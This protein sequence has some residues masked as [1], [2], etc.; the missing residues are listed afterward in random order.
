MHLAHTPADQDPLSRAL[1][2]FLA[3]RN[4]GPKEVNEIILFHKIITCGMRRASLT[5]AI[6]SRGMSGVWIWTGKWQ[7]QDGGCRMQ[8]Q[9]HH[10]PNQTTWGERQPS[11]FIVFLIVIF[12]FFLLLPGAFEKND[13][14]TCSFCFKSKQL[15][16]QYFNDCVDGADLA[17]NL[18]STF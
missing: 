8:S 11:L 18:A 17:E 16:N 6:K 9:Y 2:F 12:F 3:N 7:R 14:D 5:V 15:F 10:G 13:L 1:L 4:A